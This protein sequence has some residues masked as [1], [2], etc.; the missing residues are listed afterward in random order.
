[1]IFADVRRTAPCFTII[2][3]E[4]FILYPNQPST[5]AVASDRYVMHI[6]IQNLRTK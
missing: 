3:E 5:I 1:M 4:K 6:R 2:L